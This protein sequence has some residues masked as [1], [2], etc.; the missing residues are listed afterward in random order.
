MSSFLSKR[1][2]T[3]LPLMSLQ[4]TFKILF[5]SLKALLYIFSKYNNNNNN[6]Y[7]VHDFVRENMDYRYKSFYSI[8]VSRKK[9]EMQVIDVYM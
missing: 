1:L 6:R 7:P 3:K 4:T 8:G 5:L 9:I 2:S